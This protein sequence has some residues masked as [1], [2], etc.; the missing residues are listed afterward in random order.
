MVRHT[1]VGRYP[2]RGIA[3]TAAF[4]AGRSRAIFRFLTFHSC[5]RRCHPPRLRVLVP[6]RSLLLICLRCFVSHPPLRD[7]LSS[8]LATRPASLAHVSGATGSPLAAPR[9]RVPQPPVSRR[10]QFSVFTVYLFAPVFSLHSSLHAY[11][12]P[13]LPRR[14]GCRF[15]L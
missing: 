11:L 7:C 1:N 8:G 14:S 12:S 13:A 2:R 10:Y 15:D 9:R 6:N 4:S 3:G 5:T